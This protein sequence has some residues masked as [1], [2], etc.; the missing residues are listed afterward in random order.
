METPQHRV[1]VVGALGA[2]GRPHEHDLPDAEAHVDGRAGDAARGAVAEPG[3]G[4]VTDEGPL[5][6][7]ADPR[8]GL[9]GLGLSMIGDEPAAMAGFD[10]FWWAPLGL[11]RMLATPAGTHPDEF[12]LPTETPRHKSGEIKVEVED[13]DPRTFSAEESGEPQN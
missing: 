13:I 11:M 5:G 9:R 4:Q 7:L 12:S 6:R 8:G 2:E 1:L 10:R 3:E